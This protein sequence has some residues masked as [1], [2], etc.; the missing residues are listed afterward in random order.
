MGKKFNG[1]FIQDK[2]KVYIVVFMVMY[3]VDE[4]Y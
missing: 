4:F 3:F 2:K 1:K